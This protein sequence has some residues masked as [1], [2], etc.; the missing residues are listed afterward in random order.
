MVVSVLMLVVY[1]LGCSVLCVLGLDSVRM[2]VDLF[3]GGCEVSS[4][5]FMEVCFYWMVWL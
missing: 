3:L 5:V 2:S 4:L 1:M